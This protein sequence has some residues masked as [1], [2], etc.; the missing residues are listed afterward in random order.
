MLIVRLNRRTGGTDEAKLSD[1]IA[2]N[3]DGGLSWICRT[4]SV[5][6]ADDD[7]VLHKIKF[8]QEG[9]QSGIIAECTIGKQRVINAL[10]RLVNNR[11][12]NVQEMGK[13][14]AKYYTVA[15]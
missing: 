5:M 10:S 8:L 11:K 15:E 12:A 14:H 2:T 3:R 9:T 6:L 1:E 7:L 13:Y 4:L